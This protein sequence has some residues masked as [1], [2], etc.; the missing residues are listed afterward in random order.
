MAICKICGMTYEQ[1]LRVI[2]ACS[3]VWMNQDDLFS[4]ITDFKINAAVEGQIVDES[5]ILRISVPNLEIDI[6]VFKQL[7]VPVVFDTAKAEPVLAKDDISVMQKERIRYKHIRHPDLDIC[8]C[9]HNFKNKECYCLPH[10]ENTCMN[11]EADYNY[12]IK[13]I[14]QEFA[15]LE[16]AADH[17]KLIAKAEYHLGFMIAITPFG[18]MEFPRQV[19]SALIQENNVELKFY[20][21]GLAA[22]MKIAALMDKAELIRDA[23][24]ELKEIGNFTIRTSNVEQFKVK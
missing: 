24:D 12:E 20:N 9:H 21:I 22:I 23:Y 4:K 6:D 11:R 5:G 14:V 17:A 19:S 2:S 13:Q 10:C 7:G 16:N 1:A 8:P 3:H 15:K 18:P